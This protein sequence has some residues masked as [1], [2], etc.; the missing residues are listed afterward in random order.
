MANNYIVG[1][2]QFVVSMLHEPHSVMPSLT[3]LNRR[4]V[5][6]S[7]SESDQNGYCSY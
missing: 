4:K 5:E 7:D 1:V 6:V 2:L 3:M